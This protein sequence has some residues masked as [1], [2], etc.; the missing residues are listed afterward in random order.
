MNVRLIA[1][2]LLSVPVISC[3]AR[4]DQATADSV[5]VG[6]SSAGAPAAGTSTGTVAV[7]D[8]VKDSTEASRRRIG[9]DSPPVAPPRVPPT[10]MNGHLARLQAVLDT[11][12]GATLKPM[13]LNHPQ[14]LDSTLNGI[15]A[16]LKQSNRTPNAAWTALADSLRKDLTTLSTIS[17]DQLPAFMRSHHARI[18]RLLQMPRS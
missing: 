11:A 4:N 18:T 12:S 5:T 14:M 7:S 3:R 16:E 1:L 8:A 17:D 10:T 15:T 13:L 2:A 9:E 6:G